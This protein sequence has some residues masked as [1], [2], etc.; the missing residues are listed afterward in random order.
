MSLL[1]DSGH[2]PPFLFSPPNLVIN[3]YKNKGEG[4]EAYCIGG[5]IGCPAISPLLSGGMQ[6]VREL[7][8][9]WGKRAVVGVGVAVVVGVVAVVGGFKQNQ[10]RGSADI[11]GKQREYS[12]HIRKNSPVGVKVPRH[13]IHMN[14][15]TIHK[16]AHA[17]EIMPVDGHAHIETL[18]RSHI[19][20]THRHSL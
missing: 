13:R 1:E 7:L 14:T 2:L 5:W 19:Y 8:L 6:Q 3:L 11:E 15:S 4:G 16:E 18:T 17:Y 12:A 9:G 10:K 20:I